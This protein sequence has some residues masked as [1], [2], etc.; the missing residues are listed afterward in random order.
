MHK[1]SI[2]IPHFNYPKSLRKLLET[3]IRE[4]VEAQ[5][6]VVDDNSTK[7]I[8]DY[9]ALIRDF[10]D[11]VEF[12]TND[13]GNKGAGAARNVGL[14]KAEGEWLLFADADDYL[15]EGWYEA[16]KGYT[17]KEY[18]IVYFV[19][20]SVEEG[21]SKEG[22]RHKHYEELIEQYISSDASK[23]AAVDLKYLSVIPVS[24]LI[25]A[26]VVRDNDVRFDEIRNYDDA[27]FSVMTAFYAK[28]I[29]AD[30]KHIYCIVEHPGSL[31]TDKKEDTYE[32]GHLVFCRRNK[33]L[34]EHL[35][36]DEYDRYKIQM[37][38]YG[39]LVEALRRKCGLVRFM[40]YLDMY[41]KYKVPIIGIMSY[42]AVR[43]LKSNER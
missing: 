36:K 24:K 30:T 11:K 34:R 28:E 4:A 31:T 9:Q 3:I 43:K 37:G 14:S 23:N 6:I 26:S 15:L 39:R 33:F 25:R 10:S 17:D 8:E 19:P 16:V 38:A 27:M 7:G 22:T 5:I 32:L 40:K 13:T 41:R 21:S 12:Y 18:D 29:S 1:L 35:N 42:L 2:I 20:T